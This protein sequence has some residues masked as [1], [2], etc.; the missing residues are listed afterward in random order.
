MKLIPFFKLKEIHQMNKQKAFAEAQTQYH[1]STESWFGLEGNLPR[2]R[3]WGANTTLSQ[4]RLGLWISGDVLDLQ[5][6]V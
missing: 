5:T 3:S 6:C 2:G 1:R 4:Q